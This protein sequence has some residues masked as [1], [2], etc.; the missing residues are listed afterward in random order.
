MNNAFSKEVLSSN[1]LFYA[2]EY[3]LKYYKLVS[4]LPSCIIKKMEETNAII[5]G[6]AITSIFSE[7]PI[8]DYDVYFYTEKELEAFNEYLNKLVDGKEDLDI[9]DRDVMDSD[10]RCTKQCTSSNAWTYKVFWGNKTATIQVIMKCT[11]STYCD[12]NSSQNPYDPSL[13]LSTFDF[14]VCM[15][16]L[17]VKSK[18]FIL[19][20]DFLVHLCSRR[21]IYNTKVMTYPICSL[22]RMLKYLKKG[23]SI[24]GVEVI[25]ICIAITQLKLKTWQDF[26]EQ[27]MGID[28]QVFEP[29]TDALIE[30]H[31]ESAPIDF[32]EILEAIDEY[33]KGHGYEGYEQG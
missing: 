33:M 5:A 32:G 10:F 2:A 8:S 27:L 4:G 24:S 25:K 16:A 28:T 12:E 9:L 23:F 31:G 19:Y 6:G 15:G 18:Q 13:L 20:K 22:H 26:K 30:N 29:L 14:T 11:C 1:S 21:L 17:D 3:E 7:S